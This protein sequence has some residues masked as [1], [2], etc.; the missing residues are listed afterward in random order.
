[1][2]VKRVEVTKPIDNGDGTFTLLETNLDE[3]VIAFK[4]ELSNKKYRNLPSPNQRAMAELDIIATQYTYQIMYITKGL[5]EANEITSDKYGFLTANV[6]GFNRFDEIIKTRWIPNAKK[7]I[8]KQEAQ[9][10]AKLEQSQT[11]KTIISEVYKP[12]KTGD[13]VSVPAL[14]TITEA[15]EQAAE[16]NQQTILNSVDVAAI[17]AEPTCEQDSIVSVTTNT[18]NK[19]TF[20]KTNYQFS[21]TYTDKETG[22][23]K[24]TT[25]KIE[26]EKDWRSTAINGLSKLVLWV[27]L[28]YAIT[29][30]KVKQVYA[31]VVETTRTIYSNFKRMYSRKINQEPI[32]LNDANAELVI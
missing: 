22:E 31:D 1:M 17:V 16:L 7:I 14:T 20:D 8:A 28:V 24:E 10:L 29:V 25:V 13:V 23:F 26:S 9:E 27:R 32:V 18:G 21:Y 3:I 6:Q 4:K 12:A 2:K 15:L 11:D 30:Y 19:W 5:I